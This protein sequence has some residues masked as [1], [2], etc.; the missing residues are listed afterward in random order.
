MRLRADLTPPGRLTT[1]LERL[2]PIRLV[3]G[4]AV[5]TLAIALLLGFFVLRGSGSTRVDGIES[6]PSEAGESNRPVDEPGPA[7]TSTVSGR[8]FDRPDLQTPSSTEAGAT[9]GPVT[10]DRTTPTRSDG[11]PGSETTTTAPTTTAGSSTIE[12]SSTSRDTTTTTS[13]ITTTEA[14]APTTTAEQTTTSEGTTTSGAETTTTTA[15]TPA[16]PDDRIDG[17]DGVD[18]VD[19][20]VVD[21]HDREASDNAR[22]RQRR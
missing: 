7:S 12:G 4:P 9:V 21:V 1:A 22:R 20:D 3:T 10:G 16:D 2:D 8:G 15:A 6:R 13:A 18:R 17:L 5:V 19:H 14:E 11:G